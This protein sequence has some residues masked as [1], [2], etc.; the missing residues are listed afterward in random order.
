MFKHNIIERSV[1]RLWKKPY[2]ST[3]VK[4]CKLKGFDVIS[5]PDSIVIGTRETDQVFLRALKGNGCWLTRYD[6]KLFDEDAV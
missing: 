5:T 1:S 4:E 2:L 3:V 6:R